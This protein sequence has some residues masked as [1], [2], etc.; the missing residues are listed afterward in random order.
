MKIIIICWSVFAA[1]V[2]AT[3]RT[4]PPSGAIVVAKSGG[5]YTGLQSAVNSIGTSNTGTV[6]IFIQPG[7]YSEQVYIPN[8]IKAKITI[9]GYTTN[10]QDYNQ[11]QVIPPP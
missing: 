2:L 5:Q 6:V 11:N 7:S 4:S 9:Y 1:I 8:T 3:S 10:D